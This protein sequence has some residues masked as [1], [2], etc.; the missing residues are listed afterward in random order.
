MR[1]LRRQSARILDLA[2][3]VVVNHIQR[4]TLLDG[5]SKAALEA[6]MDQCG[7]LTPAQFFAVPAAMDAKPEPEPGTGIPMLRWET[8]CP[9]GYP[10]NDRAQA[11]LFLPHPGAPTVLL[12]HALAS[13]SDD[14]YRGWARRFNAVGWNACFLHLP[15]HYSR[16][17]P[18]CYNGELAVTA[19]LVRTGNGLRQ[20]VV[21]LRQLITWLRGQGTREFGLWA[22]SYGAW[23]AALL[24][25]IEP[26][27]RFA[28]LQSPIV[29][30]DYTI[31]LKSAIARKL[32]SELNPA[33][34]SP[35][36]IVNRHSHLSLSDERYNSDLRAERVLLA[37]GDW[38][39][40]TGQ[41]HVRALQQAWPGSAF[42]TA[43][44]GHFGYLL[45]EACFQHLISHGFMDGKSG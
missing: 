11:L 39:Q 20:G 9:S 22:T 36:D 13:T 33:P 7:P 16:I 38:D 1:I 28:V 25:G 5:A 42:L 35:M 27:F 41:R 10:A 14:G 24:L 17:P 34:A 6:Y 15:Y 8:P 29:N 18:G 30:I 43:E 21:E 2:M 40:L 44:Q 31:C 32:R 45:A 19:D 3:C 12:L 23:I 26:D 4:R 37:T